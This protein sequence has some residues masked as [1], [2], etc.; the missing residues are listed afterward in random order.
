LGRLG[1][2][3]LIAFE[4]GQ[5]VREREVELLAE[6]VDHA[7]AQGFVAAHRHAARA[8]AQESNEEIAVDVDV[9]RLEITKALQAGDGTREVV[10]AL[11]QLCQRAQAVAGDLAQ[12]VALVE[13]PFGIRLVGQEIAAVERERTAQALDRL[14]AVAARV[15]GQPGPD[16]VLELRGVDPDM[17][18]IEQVAAACRQHERAAAAGRAIG[19]EVIAQD[20]D[21]VAQP[22]RP[23]QPGVGGQLLDDLVGVDG[24]VALGDEELEHLPGAVA[25]PAALDRPL[26]ARHAR[27]PQRLDAQGRAGGPVRFRSTAPVV[28]R[29]RAQ[30]HDEPLGIGS[31]PRDRDPG[32]RRS[33]ARRQVDPDFRQR[34]VRLEGELMQAEILQRPVRAPASEQIAPEGPATGREA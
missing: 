4:L 28:T 22:G 16:L 9:E 12:P 30:L 20:V 5:Q 13:R 32:R 10:G 17:G 14:V 3:R 11:S 27:A 26:R 29:T 25:Q 23:G 33:R 6:V 2:R 7:P 18:M 19:L 31:Q 34:A 15:R 8:A 21:E 1:L 24:P